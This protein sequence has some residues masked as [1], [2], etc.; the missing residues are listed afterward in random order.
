MKKKRNFLIP[1][2]ISLS[3]AY[4]ILA[5]RPLE[6]ELQFSPQWT[7]D[8]TKVTQKKSTENASEQFAEAI[9]FK[10]GQTLG[11]FTK[12][13]DILNIATFPYKAAISEHAYALYG[14][15]DKKIPF[16]SPDGTKSGEI[17]RTGFPFF[18][19]D[20][21]YLFLPGGA[22][23]AKISETGDI[24]WC[25]ENYAPITAFSSSPAGCV[26]GYTDGSIIS[27]TAEG[28]IDQTFKPGGSEYPIVLGAALSAS[29]NL[30]ACITG[31]NEQRFIIAKKSGKHTEI[32][33]HEY[34]NKETTRQKLVKF[35]KNE[36]TVYYDSADGLGI[37]DCKTGKSKKIKTAGH[38][39]S[40]QE[41][42]A[43]N[44]V[45]VLSRDKKRYTVLVVEPFATAAGSFSFEANTACIAVKDESLFIGR[46]NE[47]SKIQ[48]MYK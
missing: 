9:P 4:I 44:T 10:L 32:I 26:A 17:S 46:D 24:Q 25:Y 43:N 14:T 45:F 42:T 36:S 38:I 23:F 41:S 30:I 35:S 7:I 39:L 27:F 3:I 47:I 12:D 28:K 5:A 34:L 48:I 31:Q 16:F 29:G 2:C 6:R 33:H 20:N 22:S 19:G 40:I 13:G 15:N 21:R 1:L 37:V 11:Y 18:M 8:A